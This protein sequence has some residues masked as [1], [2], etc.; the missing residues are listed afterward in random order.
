MDPGS[1]PLDRPARARLGGSSVTRASTL[2][3]PRAGGLTDQV[4]ALGDVRG[5]TGGIRVRR[6]GGREV[7]AEL[8]QVA[9]DGVPP[10]PLAEHLAQPV[11]LA[12]PG[13]GAEDVADR[14]PGGGRG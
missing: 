2:G 4:V 14:E 6:G 7:A 10:V 8:V 1:P 3:G 13:G 12:Q 5:P 11:G 9:A